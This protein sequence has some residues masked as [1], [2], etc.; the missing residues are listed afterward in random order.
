VYRA[1]INDEFNMPA[2][3][4]Q[5]RF[6]V[7]PSTGEVYDISTCKSKWVSPAILRKWYTSAHNS[8]QMYRLK[9][10]KS[11][12]HDFNTDE[13]L[14]DFVV[15]FAQGNK[16][17][18]YLAVLANFRGDEALEHFSAELPE[19][20]EIVDGFTLDDNEGETMSV[21]TK[22]DGDSVGTKNSR[23]TAGGETDMDR[24]IKALA[25]GASESPSK[26][27]LTEARKSLLKQDEANR[28]RKAE[29]FLMTR[30]QSMHK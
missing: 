25:G 19:D 20:I 2:I 27:E 14:E 5:H 13:G 3:P 26:K 28:K 21:Y 1:Y 30:I 11:G 29:N 9:Y 6:F 8:L 4:V 7:D 24:L 16:D 23:S 22:D 17:A 12:Q 15:N 10:D 18:C